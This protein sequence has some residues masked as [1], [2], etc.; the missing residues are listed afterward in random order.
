MA[1][2]TSVGYKNFTYD[3]VGDFPLQLPPLRH[4]VALPW[5]VKGAAR[6]HNVTKCGWLAVNYFAANIRKAQ[7]LL[8]QCKREDIHVI[9]QELR[10]FSRS[11][12]AKFYRFLRIPIIS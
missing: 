7:L 10:R 11:T 5:D 8:A 9:A 12:D 4:L 1:N 6:L 2:S 3:Q